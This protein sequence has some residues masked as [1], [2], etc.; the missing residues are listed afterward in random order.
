MKQ[1]NE[2]SSAG[3]ELSRKVVRRVSHSE[4]IGALWRHLKQKEQT[5][6]L[7]LLALKQKPGKD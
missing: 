6:R 4:S 5:E 1:N 3:A 2:T 7:S